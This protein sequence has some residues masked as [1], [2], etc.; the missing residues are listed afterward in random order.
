MKKW[1]ICLMVLVLLG[2]G[3]AKFKA[4]M[5]R[6][7]QDAA[8][9][10]E[11]NEPTYNVPETSKDAEGLT[12][13]VTKEMVYQ[14]D[15]LLVNK[16]HPVPK[17]LHPET[18]AVSL[19]RNAELIDGFGV[20]DNKVLLSP[21]MA[22]RF[23]AMVQA[24]G[25]E[26]INHFLISSGYRDEQ[27]QD[28]L[29]RQMGSRLAL[30][31]G[32]SEH[33][34]GLSLDIGS[35]QAEMN[36]APEGQWLK[37]NAWKYGFILRYPDDKTAITGIQF[38]PWHFRYVGLPHSA[39]I[40]ENGFVLEQYMDYLKEQ[41]SVSLTVQGQ[42]YHVFYYPVSEDRTIQV[43]AQGEYEISGNNMDGIIVTVRE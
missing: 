19:I 30:P 34:L 1:M 8:Q 4:G 11:I 27:K 31:A 33:N 37:E 40:Q 23:A 13:D 43:P 26:G 29:Y 22:D 18:E 17:G 36:L 25:E 2:F 3:V 15:L 21:Q 14:G 5:A 7:P 16:D 32:Y 28:E 20:L 39:I 9:P 12:I 35:S 41:Q 24:A 38:E 10:F 42:N 6:T